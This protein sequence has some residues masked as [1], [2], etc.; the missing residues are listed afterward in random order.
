[1]TAIETPRQILEILERLSVGGKPDQRALTGAPLAASWSTI[2]G[3]DIFRVGAV[4]TTPPETRS[5]P[6]VVPLLAIDVEDKWALVLIDNEIMWWALGE[7][8]AGTRVLEDSAEVIRRAT[9]W[10]RRQLH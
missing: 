9:T 2:P 5:R 7:R 1:L 3:E 6:L 10:I 4:V 8:L